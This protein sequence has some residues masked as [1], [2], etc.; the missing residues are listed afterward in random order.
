[1]LRENSLGASETRNEQDGVGRS[2]IDDRFS[3]GYHQFQIRA[4]DVQRQLLVRFFDGFQID[5]REEEFGSYPMSCFF[6]HLLNPAPF[7]STRYLG[8]AN[9]RTDSL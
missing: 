6:E 8:D 4:R 5:F 2:T 7:G 3:P 9:H 1:M